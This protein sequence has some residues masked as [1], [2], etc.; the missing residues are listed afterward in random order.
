MTEAEWGTCNDPRRLLAFLGDDASERKLRLLACA[1]CRR[2]PG[3]LETQPDREGLELTERDVDGR[4]EER[5]FNDLPL[6]VW[7]IRWY[8]RDG[9]NAL[10][11]A[12]NSYW[13]YFWDSRNLN[14]TTEQVQEQALQQ[15]HADLVALILD[16]FG[17]PFRPLILDPSHYRT[18][19]VVSLARAAYDERQLPSGELDPHRLAVLADALEEAGAPDELVS[20]LRGPG[21]HVRGCFAVDLCLGLS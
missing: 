1:C 13:D 6:D 4:A 3:F 5:A 18:P 8:R 10:D 19:T 11:R 9:W 17:N 2:I 21:P 16:V 15:C 7:D 12:M 14:E 20:H